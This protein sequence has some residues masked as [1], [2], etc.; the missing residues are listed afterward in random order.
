MLRHM[1]ITLRL[2]ALIE[3]CAAVRDARKL[4]AAGK[5]FRR[6]KRLNER[7]LELEDIGP[8]LH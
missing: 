6:V 7:L 1:E 3:R 8:R 2:V 4:A 5:L